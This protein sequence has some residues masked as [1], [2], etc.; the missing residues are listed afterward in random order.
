MET[1]AA[2]LTTTTTALPREAA[3]ALEIEL[4]KRV[5]EVAKACYWERG[6]E[7]GMRRVYL[8]WDE[9]ALRE[10]LTQYVSKRTQGSAISFLTHEKAGKAWYDLDKAS[11]EG[12]HTDKLYALG[13]GQQEQARWQLQQLRSEVE[14]ACAA[15]LEPWLTKMAAD[16]D[17]F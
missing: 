17:I 8:N 7:K 14:K 9:E 3:R 6:E 4:P 13:K 16:P 11:L 12:L 5:P 1:M 15:I 2:E 10:R